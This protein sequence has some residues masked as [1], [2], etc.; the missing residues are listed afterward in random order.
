[1]IDYIVFDLGGVLI[2]WDPRYLY[3][4]LFEDPNEIDYFLTEVCHGKW[5]EQMDGGYPFEQA[6]NDR[7]A[8]YPQYEEAILAYWK[9]WPEM[10]NGAHPGTVELLEQMR[11]N[12]THRLFSITNWS[13]ETFP[14]ARRLF[15]FLGYFEDIV[16]SGEEKLIKPNAGIYQVLF[17]RNQLNARAGL[18]IDDN[19]NNVEAA[20]ACG[21]EAIHFKHPEQLKSDLQTFGIIR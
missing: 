19:A 15:P 1:M 3:R 10:L 21:M 16:V 6:C 14:T 8:E 4:K 17:E 11:S 18:F 20:R 13:A 9:R 7:I 5:N 12:Q 2:D